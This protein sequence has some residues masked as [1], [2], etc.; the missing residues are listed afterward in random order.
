LPPD[1]DVDDF[2]LTPAERTLLA[3]FNRR[4]RARDAGP[5]EN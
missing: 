5:G 2:A 4:G 3:A 1:G